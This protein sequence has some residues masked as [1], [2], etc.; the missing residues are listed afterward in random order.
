MPSMGGNFGAMGGYPQ[1]EA[2]EFELYALDVVQIAAVTPQD[3][4]TMDIT[5]DE[6]DINS[7]KVGMTAEVKINALGGEK[8]TATITGISN[9]GASSGG[10]SK[11]TVELTM[12]RSQN[13]L[14]GMN[15]TAAIG[16]HT[17][18]DVLTIPVSALV[19]KGTQTIVYTGYDEE[20]DL[21][22]N[23]VTVQAGVS[24]GETV[25]IL[26]GL[27]NGQTYYYA[28]YDTLEVSFTPD[29]GSGLMFGG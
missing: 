10:S 21:L 2:E 13:M 16:L 11:F 20:E 17:S 9:T 24:D 14:A 8:C 3:T 23:P 1:T 4:M 19:E 6:L 29:F 12:A 26:E 7:L 28:Y 5:I 27:S 25:Q 18:A 15:A 22:L